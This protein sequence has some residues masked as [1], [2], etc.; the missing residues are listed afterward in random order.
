MKFFIKFIYLIVNCGLGDRFG[1]K[2]WEFTKKASY[3]EKIA[4]KLRERILQL[5]G[6]C[7]IA[8]DVF[9][10]PNAT[11]DTRHLIMVKKLS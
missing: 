7:Q 4:Q 3:R 10:S 1:R 11:I 9:I 5:D 6:D 2:P 8:A